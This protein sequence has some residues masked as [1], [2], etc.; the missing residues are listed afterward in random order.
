MPSRTLILQLLV[1]LATLTSCPGPLSR[2]TPGGHYALTGY[3]AQVRHSATGSGILIEPDPGSGVS[4]GVQAVADAA[5][6]YFRRTPTGTLVPVGTGTARAVTEGDR[7]EV[8]L[9][10]PNDGG[11]PTSGRAAALVLIGTEEVPIAAY[12]AEYVTRADRLG[13]HSLPIRP[14]FWSGRT[15]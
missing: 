5:T 4:C 11:C 15:H 2:N 6:R 7:V 13:T 8:Y 3:V 1:V 10:G 9:D 12:V 14:S